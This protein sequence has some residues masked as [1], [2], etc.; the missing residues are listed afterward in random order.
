MMGRYS[1]DEPGLIYAHSG[2]K[3]FDPS[4][5]T[6]FPADEDG[7]VP[8]TETSWFPDDAAHRFEQFVKTA[9]PEEHLEENLT[10]VAANLGQKMGETSRKKKMFQEP[11]K[12]KC[13]RNR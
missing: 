2:N 12:R 3:G 5:Y 13:S 8:I 1:L 9:W 6:S 11:L 7:I 10:F 4:K